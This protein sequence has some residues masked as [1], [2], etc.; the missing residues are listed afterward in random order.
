MINMMIYMSTELAPPEDAD[1]LLPGAV[2][3]QNCVNQYS[4]SWVKSIII[5]FFLPQR[6]ICILLCNLGILLFYAFKL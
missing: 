1:C 6:Y 4:K 5:G 3:H 2:E